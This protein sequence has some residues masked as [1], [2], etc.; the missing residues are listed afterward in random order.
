MKRAIPLSRALHRRALAREREAA[1]V[2]IAAAVVTTRR[3]APRRVVVGIPHP[4]EKEQARR[5]EARGTRNSSRAA[6]ERS[7][8]V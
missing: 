8:R 6:K 3:L 1:S 7:V 4:K 2:I 5:K